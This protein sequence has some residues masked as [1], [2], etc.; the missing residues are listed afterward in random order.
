MN[1]EDDGRNNCTYTY[2][3]LDRRNVGDEDKRPNLS[4]TIA[5]GQSKKLQDVSSRSNKNGRRDRTRN[6][7][8]TESGCN[9]RNGAQR[10]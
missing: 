3:A 8:P 7:K 10:R 6:L 4:Y 1:N 5:N 9:S 2:V